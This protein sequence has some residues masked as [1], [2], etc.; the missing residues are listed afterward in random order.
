[1]AGVEG[2]R[3][4]RKG[5]G[6]MRKAADGAHFGANP[7]FCRKGLEFPGLRHEASVTIWRFRG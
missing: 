1:V 2:L 3:T 6:D 7:L 4:G 5:P